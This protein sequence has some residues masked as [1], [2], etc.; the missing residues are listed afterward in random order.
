MQKK[1]V[2]VFPAILNYAPDGISISF[3]DL[4][5]CF[6][7]AWS[8][9]EALRMAKEALGVYMWGLEDDGGELPE[10]TPLSEVQV[11]NDERSALIE[12]YM[13]LIRAENE[14]RAVKKTLTIPAWM[15]AAARAEN[16]NFSQLMQSAIL[17]SLK[18]QTAGK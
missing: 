18:Y 3:P 2:Y 11:G 15:D 7:C 10:P 5:G 1:D 16:I 4:P 14:N 6:S 13:P 17:Q 8:D 9:E 12:V